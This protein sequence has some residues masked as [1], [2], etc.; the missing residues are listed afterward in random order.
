MKRPLGRVS[1]T[2]KNPSTSESFEFWLEDSKEVRPFDIVKAQ[3]RI[4]DKNSL[5][6][7][8]VQDISHSTDSAGHLSSYI[9]SD[10]GDPESNPTTQRIG[11]TYVKA[12]VLSNDQHVYMPLRDGT[13]VFF[14]SPEEIT[15]ALGLD[16]I[17]NPIVAGAIQTSDGATVPINLNAE[18]LLGIDGAHL[19]ISGIS[20]LATK[21]SYIMFLLQAIQQ[22]LDDVAFL[23]LNVKGDD[24][25]R[26]DEKNENLTEI[27]EG[28]WHDMGLEPN[29]FSN[30]RYFYPYR[31][32]SPESSFSNSALS[33][34]TLKQQAENGI[35]S[36]FV[37]TYKEDK[38]KIDLLFSNIDDPQYTI[39]SIL[40]HIESDAAFQKANNWEALLNLL[41]KQSE[42]GKGGKQE[43]PVQSWRRFRR[44][45]SRV[46]KTQD[47]VFTDDL[48]TN[49]ERH[50]VH[51]SEEITGIK[52]GEVFVIDIAKL[53][54][55]LQLLTFGDILR[56]L[57]SLRF[58][59]D[60]PDQDQVP[61][62]IVVFVDELNKYAGS[63]TPKN[64]AILR[65][66]LEITERGRS[67]GLILFSAE[68]FRSAI[69]DRVKGNCSTH[70]Y[71]RT[72]EVEIS[73]SDYK[74]LPRLFQ[75]MMTRLPKGE[76]ILQHAIYSSPLKITF[77][78]PCYKQHST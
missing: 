31:G 33:N 6:F 57:Q 51:L 40:S 59:E 23:I 42:S 76:L 70:V 60:R 30:V 13:E 52:P 67:E 26:L 27:Q 22:K 55:N 35:L 61:K 41:S 38:A 32:K 10:F 71:G 63:N 78:F 1:A 29:P 66:L 69:H 77:P 50:Q 58:G 53:D 4:G 44:L 39:E 65:N 47:S 34:E 14:A 18:F 20:G 17:K 2:E 3:N 56:S 12:R 43:I 54:D 75:S 9:S 64:S 49:P 62:R 5:T 16:K 28:L 45:L 36:N 68:Q 11:V 48:S 74:F 46:I 21:T 19:N 72:N 15:K 24:L 25:L 7:G 73:K 8:V 37:Y